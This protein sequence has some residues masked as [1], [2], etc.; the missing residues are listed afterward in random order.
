M[1]PPRLCF[2]TRPRESL[3]F[4]YRCA[5][6][7]SVLTDAAPLHTGTSGLYSQSR[8]ADIHICAVCGGVEG[9]VLTGAQQQAF[10]R[11]WERVAT[12]EG[13]P[14]CELVRRV[15]L[16]ADVEEARRDRRA[17]LL[18]YATEAAACSAPEFREAILEDYGTWGAE[19]DETEEVELEQHLA[20]VDDAFYLAGFGMDEEDGEEDEPWWQGESIDDFD[21]DM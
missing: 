7:D 10:E 21:D 14:E 13:L 9:P 19:L 4:G 6:F 8:L 18:A 11:Q 15:L 20:E 12:M 17:Q 5:C 1:R 3:A 2:P 16:Q